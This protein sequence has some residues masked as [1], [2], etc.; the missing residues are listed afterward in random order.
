M[1]RGKSKKMKAAPQPRG[2]KKG[3]RKSKIRGLIVS[4][5]PWPTHWN[6]HRVSY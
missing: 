3:G 1:S 4:E 6:N 2:D 5:Q